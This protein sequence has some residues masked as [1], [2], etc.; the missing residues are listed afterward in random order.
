MMK[1]VLFAV[2]GAGLVACGGGGGGGDA[3]SAAPVASAELT[4]SNAVLIAGSTTDAALAS[5]EFDQFANLGVLG[6]PGGTAAVQSAGDASMA[7]AKQT[8]GLR[9]TTAE[10]SVGP[11]VQ[12]CPLGGTMTISATIA[13]P[14]TL[15]AGDSFSITYA[16]CDFGE[17]LVANGGMGFTVTSFSGD[18][19]GE[20]FSVGFDIDVND[21]SMTESGEAISL[22]G[23]FAISMSMTATSSVITLSGN[24]LSVSNGIE[25]FELSGFSTTTTLDLSTFPESFSIESSGFLMSSEF[26]G[27]VEFRTTVA[28]QGNGAGHP[29][30]GEFLVIGADGASVTVLPLDEQNA[31]I[32]LDLDGDGAVDP[33]GTLD[34]TWEA[35][36][37]T[38]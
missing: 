12:E 9:A 3:Q 28:L 31:R 8:A 14:E 7:L 6:S 17:G 15:S 19:S 33:D 24:S 4:T 37:N 18:M 21:F 35:F 29:V 10:V 1:R 26:D 38:G 25:F 30:S 5:T 22:D 27:E 34:M 13:N 11:E 23:D 20:D 2:T 36:L 32:E 16:D